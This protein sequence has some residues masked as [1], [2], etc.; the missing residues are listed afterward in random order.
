MTIKAPFP[1]FGGKSKI[2]QSIWNYIGA[3]IPNYVEPFAGSLAV[4]LARPGGAGKI[5]TVNDF[6]GLLAN[7]WR[8]IKQDP[9][10]TAHYADWP[11]NENDLHARHLWL[12]G[13][14]ENLT[15][16]LICDPE[17]Y[18]AKAAGWWVWGACAWI[19][20]GFCSGVGPWTVIDGI[21][22][23]SSNAGQGISR[24]LPHVGDAGNGINRKLPH[25]GNAGRGEFIIEWFKAIHDR[26]R[27]VR[28]AVGDFERVLASSVTD[29]HGLT[30]IFLDPPYDTDCTDPYAQNG[31]G[32]SKRTLDWCIQNGYNEKLR[33]VLCGYSGE[34]DVLTSLGW[35]EVPWSAKGGYSN[36]G[37]NKNDNRHRERL[38]VSPYCNHV[39][40]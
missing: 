18:D 33:I 28:V 29:L 4:L 8:S 30:G 38:W 36:T 40:G 1:Y 39:I 32:V 3:D 12:V 19:G 23:K 2:A 5:E 11:V 26:I 22:T 15:N 21:F 27:D 6:D 14:R 34:H 16:Q 7:V 31:K 24:K 9:E 25:V 35:R 37:A 20:S 13:Q 10:L 17:F